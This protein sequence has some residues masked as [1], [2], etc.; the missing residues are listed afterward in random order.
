[1]ERWREEVELLEEELLRLVDGYSML[2]GLWGD[3]CAGE[4]GG[5]K[6]FAARKGSDYLDHLKKTIKHVEDLGLSG[7]SGSGSQPNETC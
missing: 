3:V 6:A 2:S 4:Q 7:V 5:R 1:M